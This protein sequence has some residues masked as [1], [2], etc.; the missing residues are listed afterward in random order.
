MNKYAIVNLLYGTGTYLIGACINAQ[1]HKKF[2]FKYNLMF[3]IVLMVDANLYIYKDILELFYDK[4]I[5]IDMISVKLNEDYK[6]IINKRYTNSMHLYSTKYNFFKLIEYE[7]ILLVDIDILPVDKNFYNCFKYNTPASMINNLDIYTKTNIK[8]SYN[9]KDFFNRDLENVK[10]TD[11]PTISNNIKKFINAGLL[12]ISPKKDDF[13]NI[14]KF[15]K[16]AEN[17]NG[18]SSGTKGVAVDETILMLYYLYNK[19]ENIYSLDPNMTVIP[20]YKNSD[21]NNKYSINYLSTI[22][23]WNKP[24]IFMHKEEFIYK[25][26]INNVIKKHKLLKT[27]HLFNIAKTI[28]N[29]N[30]NIDFLSNRCNKS[31]MLKQICNDNILKIKKMEEIIVQPENRENYENISNKI[32]KKLDKIWRNMNKKKYI[33]NF[34]FGSVE[35]IVNKLVDVFKK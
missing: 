4:I 34:S 21:T 11:L 7:K 2:R 28:Y 17:G 18:Y 19:K 1:V 32:E 3:D 30:K 29:Y 13:D 25:Y 24:M 31:D 10:D 33:L 26:L 20:W 14:L 35:S 23:P 16:L 8:K 9:M 12:L 22:K 15:I 6:K 5:L 27:I